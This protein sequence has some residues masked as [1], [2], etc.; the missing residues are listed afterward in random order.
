VADEP[1][2]DVVARVLG[3]GPRTRRDTYYDAV[4]LA[5][6]VQRLTQE[7]EHHIYAVA[8]QIRRAETAEERVARVTEERDGLRA[9]LD[10]LWDVVEGR[11]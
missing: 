8:H 9:E 1:I 3:H 7:N 2:A 11:R 10:R 6:E 4:T 5:R